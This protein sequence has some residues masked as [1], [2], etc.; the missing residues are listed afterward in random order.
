MKVRKFKKVRKF[1]E[2]KVRKFKKFK[3]EVQL[4]SLSATQ[5][6]KASGSAAREGICRRMTGCFND[7]FLYDYVEGAS[8]ALIPPGSFG[9]GP[10]AAAKERIAQRIAY[11]I[12]Y[13]L[14]L[15]SLAYA[16]YLIGAGKQQVYL[17][18]VEEWVPTLALIYG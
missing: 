1:N 17:T 4:Q 16:F 2:E 12:Y 5:A 14:L 3:F 11:R 15:F 9:E 10:D 7:W 6:S 8:E 13:F 18:E